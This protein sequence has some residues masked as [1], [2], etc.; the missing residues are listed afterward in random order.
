MLVKD[1]KDAGKNI[2]FS[3][4]NKRLWGHRST[5]EGALRADG[6][7]YGHLRY[8]SNAQRVVLLKLGN[9]MNTLFKRKCLIAEGTMHNTYLPNLALC[10]Y[11]T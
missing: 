10:P 7:K 3:N 1:I 11:L 5:Q 8:C 2:R 6:S 9:S 4:I